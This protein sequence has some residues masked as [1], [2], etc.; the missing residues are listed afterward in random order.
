MA[1]APHVIRSSSN[2]VQTGASELGESLRTRLRQSLEQPRVAAAPVADGAWRQQVDELLAA[3]RNKDEFLAVLGHE[4]RNPLGAMRTALDILNMSN[5]PPSASG[6]A[7][8]IINR[9]LL[10]MT[11]LIDDMLDVARI[12]QGKISCVWPQPISSPCCDRR[13]TSSHPMWRNGIRSS[14]FRCYWA[15]PCSATRCGSNKR[16][17][18]C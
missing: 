2:R 12:T 10:N 16:S 14:R 6:Q 4:L 17:G 18:T 9:Q 1:I 7:R 15:A 3:G 11:R 5:A 13:W 8:V